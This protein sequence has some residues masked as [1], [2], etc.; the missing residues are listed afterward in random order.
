MTAS[1][2]EANRRL[3][4]LTS[5]EYARA[6]SGSYSLHLNDLRLRASVIDADLKF[7][8]DS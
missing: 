6:G 1:L 3:R 4:D 2:R 5:L 7:V 8:Y